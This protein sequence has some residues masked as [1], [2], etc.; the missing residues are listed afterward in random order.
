MTSLQTSFH[1]NMLALVD[2]IQLRILGLKDILTEYLKHREI[3]V[4]RR[5]EY[6]LKKARERAHILEGL[7]IALD[8]I[9]AV[10][11]LIRASKSYEEA[12]D[13]LM[14]QFKLRNQAQ[15]IPA[16]Q[17]RKLTGLERQAIEDELKELHKLIKE[18]ESILAD[19]QNPSYHPRRAARDERKIRRRST[20]ANHQS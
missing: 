13:G 19:E 8:N 12:R 10:I 11:A 5:T 17:L 20:H 15:A 14:K 3:A 18:L 7:K 16:M 9:D 1:Y 6:E 4:R 2:G